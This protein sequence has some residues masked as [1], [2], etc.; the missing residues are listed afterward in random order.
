M[1]KTPSALKW[2]AEK[3]ARVAFDLESKQTILRDLE[4]QIAALQADLASLDRSIT[5]YDSRI[6]PKKIAPIN[7]WWKDSYGKRGALKEAM[8]GF[9]QAAAPHPISTAD[10]EILVCLKFGIA[11]ATQEERS[12]WRK[13]G[14]STAIKRLRKEDL[15]ER[16]EPP[17]MQGEFAHWRWKLHEN[18]LEALERTVAMKASSFAGPAEPWSPWVDRLRGTEA[19]HRPGSHAFDACHA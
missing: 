9:I 13:G 5:I 10:L 14:F 6:D 11:F 1:K 12:Q 17:S 16:V 18:S 8:S 2:L 4:S 19:F 7:G 15:I 3:R